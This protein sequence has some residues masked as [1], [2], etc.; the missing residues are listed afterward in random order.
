MGEENKYN[1]N[2]IKK[3]FSF[4]DVFLS[5]IELSTTDERPKMLYKAFFEEIGQIVKKKLLQAYNEK[6]SSIK[7]KIS[8]Y[9]N[10]FD[11]NF[12]ELSETIHSTGAVQR[13][14]KTVTFED[15]YLNILFI[16]CVDKIETPELK[17]NNA[18]NDLIQ[19]KIIL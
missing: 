12:I 15:T 19:E 7:K 1:V 17:D 13:F 16:K 5:I 14:Y 8:D 2:V 10:V 4:K 3:Y 9:Y 18:K 6:R 11:Q